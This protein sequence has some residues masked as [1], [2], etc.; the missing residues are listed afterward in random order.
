[1]LS[2]SAFVLA[3]VFTGALM[4][5]CGAPSSQTSDGPEGTQTAAASTGEKVEVEAKVAENL[6]SA[7]PLVACTTG[8]HLCRTGCGTSYCE[9]DGVDCAYCFKEGKLCECY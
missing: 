6:K 9:E 5:A 1:M 4:I 7:Q 3:S 8:E 2:K